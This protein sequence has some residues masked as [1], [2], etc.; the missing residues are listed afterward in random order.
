MLCYVR[1]HDGGM[2]EAGVGAHGARGFHVP[3]APK[4]ADERQS[5]D[6][7]AGLRGAGRAPAGC[8]DVCAEPPRRE[9]A[10]GVRAH[11]GEHDEPGV[12]VCE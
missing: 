10:A 4:G 11:D 6:P 3:C 5:A 7:R 9:G 1:E 12:V 8:G 2:A